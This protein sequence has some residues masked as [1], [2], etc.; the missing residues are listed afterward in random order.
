MAFLTNLGGVN[1][2]LHLPIVKIKKALNLKKP[3]D[4]ITV[5]SSL[6]IFRV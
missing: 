5:Y 2:L 1:A 6:V 3:E 4:T